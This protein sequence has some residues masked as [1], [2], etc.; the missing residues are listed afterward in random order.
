MEAS[1]TP[2]RTTEDKP[3]GKFEEF[4]LNEKTTVKILTINP[5]EELSLQS[6]EHRSEWWIVLD[7]AM[8]VVLND[9]QRTLHRGDE[10]FIPAGSKHRVIGLDQSCRWLE[11]AYGRFDE[12]DIHRFDDKYGR[13]NS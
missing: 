4:T 6:H 1:H 8:D 10:I 2:H 11:I 3:W 5:G 9:E 7:E 13:A 12:G